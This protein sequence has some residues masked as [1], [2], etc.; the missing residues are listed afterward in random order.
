MDRL[1]YL[2]GLVTL[3]VAV[4]GAA[5]LL[6]LLGDEDRSRYFRLNLQFRDVQGLLPGADVK[7]RGA[8]VG[9]VHRVT[10]RDDGRKG[11]ASIRLDPGKEGLARTNSR[12]WIVT[13]RFG[14]LAAGASGLETLVRDA[15]VSFLTPEPWCPPLADGS[16]VA[17]LERPHV[18]DPEA[19]LDPVRRGDLSMT[20]LIPENYGLS[21]GAGVLFRGVRTGEVRTV[22]LAPD[23]SHVRVGLRL[24]RDY[25][26]T[27][28]DKTRFWVARPRLSGALLGGIALDD[29]SALLSPFVG[30]HTESGAGLPVPDGWAVAAEVERPSLDLS[31]VVAVAGLERASE[32][33]PAADVDAIQLVRVLYEA[34]EEDWLSANDEIRREGTGLLYEDA[35]GRLLVLTARSACDGAFFEGDALGSRPEIEGE[36]IS[37]VLP[38][39]TVYRGLRT[40]VEPEGGDLA[41]LVLDVGLDEREGLASTPLA[42]FAFEGDRTPGSGMSLLSVTKDGAVVA[43]NTAAGDA[44]PSLETH[45]G[46]AAVRD[47]LVVGLVGEAAIASLAP[48]PP[49]L[50]P[51]K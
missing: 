36:G 23:G 38:D 1:R 33:A 18:E 11:V 34:T 30:Y 4:G 14:G 16:A 6:Q 35:E 28:T 25:R 22:R 39:G 32:R 26:R 29:V 49:A 7:Y 9:S 13:P 40:W 47:G 37:I 46:A 17:G 45:R 12:F 24:E 5:F 20:L 51:A 19:A 3:A 41:L 8:L 50:R 31:K 44:L 15:Y 27:V 21:P 48:I 43:A 42:R 2:I 10:L